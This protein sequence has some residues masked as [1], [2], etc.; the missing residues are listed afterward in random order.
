MWRDTDGLSNGK[1]CLRWG[2]RIVGNPALRERRTLSVSG[3]ADIDTATCNAMIKY[4]RPITLA[5]HIRLT[6]LSR[7]QRITLTPICSVPKVLRFQTYRLRFG[8][9]STMTPVPLSR[10]GQGQKDRREGRLC[11]SR[12]CP[13]RQQ[14][15]SERRSCTLRAACPYHR[16]PPPAPCRFRKEQSA[17]CRLL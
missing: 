8:T 9:D 5:R 2:F 6:R 15:V 3:F 11:P 12:P 13:V 4:L 10:T 14:L 17:A 7:R 16:S 1:T